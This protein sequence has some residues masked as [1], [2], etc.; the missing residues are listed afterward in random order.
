MSKTYEEVVSQ[1]D[2]DLPRSAVQTREGGNGMKLSYVSGYYV[3]DRLNKVIGIG[4]YAYTHDLTLLP[5]ATGKQTDKYGKERYT[6][7]YLAKVRLMVKFPN[8]ETTEFTDVGYG[9]GKDANAGKAHESA[10]KEAVTDGLKRCAKN[11]GMSMGL[12]LYDKAQENVADEE[13][14]APAPKAQKQA[15]APVA[16][17]APE[18]DKQ[19]VLNLISSTSRVVI[20]KKKA[21]VDELKDKLKTYG[22]AAKEELNLKDAQK[23]LEELKGMAQ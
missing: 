8:G 2:A 12:A 7:A 11:L 16:A 19:K 5:D 10:S 22:V 4:N 3:V 15:S 9:D 18:E 1:L 13:A 23:F 14:E 6:A 20:A 21:T 17:A